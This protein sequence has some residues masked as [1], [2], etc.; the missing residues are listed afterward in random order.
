[1]IEINIKVIGQNAQALKRYS[2]VAGSV[3]D[4]EAIFTFD[5]SWDG[6]A[7]SVQ[8]SNG[9]VHDERLLTNDRTLIPTTVISESGY[10]YIKPYA[11]VLDDTGHILEAQENHNTGIN[12]SYQW[13]D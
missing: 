7:K 3:N 9:T 8:F 13:T 4:H 10:L 6:M 11:V 1:M 12:R 5:T 2:I